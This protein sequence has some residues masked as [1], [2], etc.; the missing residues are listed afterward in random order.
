[1]NKYTIQVQA[2][3][4]VEGKDFE[5]ACC[6]AVQ[7]AMNME[8]TEWGTIE[9]PNAGE[10][11]DGTL[12][13]GRTD[14]GEI[15]INHP[16]LKPDRNGVGHIIFSPAQARGLAALLNKHAD[17]A[18]PQTSSGSKLPAAL[19]KGF[20]QMFDCLRNASADE[21]RILLSWITSAYEHRAFVA[22]VNGS[23][24][25]GLGFPRGEVDTAWFEQLVKLTA[26]EIIAMEATYIEWGVTP[27]SSR[28]LLTHSLRKFHAMA[29]AGPAQ[30]PPIRYKCAFCKDGKD[31]GNYPALLEHFD[32]AHDRA[33]WNT[34]LGGA[35]KA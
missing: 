28:E 22:E 13:V 35:V 20:M 15:V 9:I 34:E 27:E 8:S 2:Q 11:R 25:E 3:F 14:K 21:S 24:A 31:Y 7:Q 17:E 26:A 23:I 12:W 16:D 6:E 33:H 1:V 4:D 10:V 5:D 18:E 29:K 30:K 32:A 19:A